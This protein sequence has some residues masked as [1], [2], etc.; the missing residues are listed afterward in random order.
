[1]LVRDETIGDGEQMKLPQLQRG[2]NA[3]IRGKKTRERG[4]RGLDGICFFFVLPLCTTTSSHRTYAPSLV[5]SS[6]NELIERLD[7]KIA[8]LQTE[9]AFLAKARDESERKSNPHAVSL[10]VRASK[11]NPHAVSLPVR[12]S[13]R[14]APVQVE[15]I[16]R[17]WMEAR[18]IP[19]IEIEEQSRG[20][21]EPA[22]PAT[23]LYKLA[24]KRYQQGFPRVPFSYVLPDL[25][26]S[27]DRMR[28]GAFDQLIRLL[29]TGE[30]L[31]DKA[32]D[33]YS[34]EEDDDEEEEEDKDKDD[35]PSKSPR[36]RR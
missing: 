14:P 4:A 34:S 17:K 25:F 31:T 19:D 3:G 20:S 18:E 22:F 12:A 13:Y 1:L 21:N 33:D 15:P 27:K 10:P 23:M 29:K 35:I 32:N 16:I 5:M 28:R 7:H 11:S 6:F 8:D 30:G 9:R 26:Y 24:S 2:K 36:R